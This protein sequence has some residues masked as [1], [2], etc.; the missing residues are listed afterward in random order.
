MFD[1]FLQLSRSLPESAR[2]WPIQLCSSYF[3]D[4]V[5][6]LV[7]QILT[8]LFQMPLILNMYTELDQLAYFK[9]VIR[10]DST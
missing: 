6:E 8:G 3:T 9:E 1:K 5:K 4:L 10:S 7:D 2:A